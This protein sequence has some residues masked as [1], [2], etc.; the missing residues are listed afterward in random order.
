MSERRS[1]M[2]ADRRLLALPLTE[3]ALNRSG[4]LG[5][6]ARRNRRPHT[7]STGDDVAN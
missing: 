7:F 1:D 2:M 4:G 6:Q 5:F 3:T